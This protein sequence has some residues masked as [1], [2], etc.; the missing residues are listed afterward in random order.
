[1]QPILYSNGLTLC[2]ATSVSLDDFWRLLNH[3]DVRRY[4]CDDTEMS[5]NDVACLLHDALEQGRRGLG[6]WAIRR[7]ETTMG[8]VAL[9]PVL[10]GAVAVAPELGGMIEPVIAL[11]PVHWRRGHA[12]AAMTAVL[13]YAFD[14]LRYPALA[15]L[16]DVPNQDSHR[17]MQRLGF[18]AIGVIPGPRY[19]IRQ[20]RLSP[21]GFAARFGEPAAK[22]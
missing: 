3:P 19:A 7:D 5:R 14:T 22:P 9:R 11:N 1:M 6:L 21:S 16:V 18:T 17:L 20:Y 10:D 8:Y 4:L 2:P 15:A 13:Q 12:M